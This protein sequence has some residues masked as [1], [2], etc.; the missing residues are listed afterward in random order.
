MRQP[1]AD[2]AR[3]FLAGAQF[4]W[5]QQFE[6]APGLPTPGVSPA[7]WLL[8]A[9][10]VPRDLHGKTV[11]DIGTT[12]GAVAFE[13]ERRG[14]D[15]VVAV[16]ILDID[17]FGFRALAELF[18]S[19]AEFLQCSLYELPDVLQETFDVVVFW[20]VLYHLRHPLLGLDAVRR[21]ARDVVY[22]ETAV[23]DFRDGSTE[24]VARFHQLD[25][26]GGDASNWWSP[27]SAALAAWCR[28][29]GFDV[30]RTRTLPD[31]E[32][33]TRCLASL[34]VTP[35][36]PEY[37][38]V[39]YEK[40]LRVRTPEPPPLPIPPYEMR[41]LV[42]PT[43]PADFDN[44][45]GALVVPGVGVE[46]YEAVFDWGCGCG[47]VAR[48]LMQQDPR[49]SRYLGI[50]LHRGMVEWCRTNLA[51]HDVRFEFLHHD[52]YEKGFNPDATDTWLPFP[53]P[54][55]TFTLALAWSVFTHVN[56]EQ[57]V[58]YLHE[59]RRILRDDGVLY[60]TWFLFDKSDY[61]MMDTFQN[62]L[63]INDINP[64]NAVIFDREWLRR[65]VRE[66]GFTMFAAEPPI[67]RGYQWSLW[68]TP[69]EA[70]RPD[71]ELP[72]DT[73]PAGRLVPKR[74]RANPHEIGLS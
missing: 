22:L 14:A 65:T 12:N 47:R 66:A 39:S 48:K 50:D 36:A 49:P 33:A 56:E 23:A 71:V 63:F 64:T 32:P 27:T 38:R 18:D 1:A 3:A 53:A 11:L 31:G 15:R 44:A 54:E 4:V 73:A 55:N 72:D 74:A 24:T 19:K 16:D 35:D 42:G 10:D 21:V 70:G 5:H 26:L 52:V 43:D 67:L 20:G 60:S 68:L 34:R 58:R 46:Q 37:L 29:A 59:M 2:E 13:A 51:P 61:P 40:E 28:S 57:A 9:F 62:A 25:D 8:A 45:D 30:E 6:L 7:D 69:T 41:V 17:W